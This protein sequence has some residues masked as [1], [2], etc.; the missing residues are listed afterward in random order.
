MATPLPITV[1]TNSGKVAL[2]TVPATHL[3]TAIWSP[4][5]G[6]SAEGANEWN[7]TFAI[8]GVTG[9]NFNYY[10]TGV[11]MPHDAPLGTAAK[12]PGSGTGVTSNS[13]TNPNESLKNAESALAETDNPRNRV[14]N[15]E[16]AIEPSEGGTPQ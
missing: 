11:P 16:L 12:E 2:A 8:Y 5:A 13:V 1:L 10:M 4:V 14:S 7:G 6:V 15:R 9:S 3:S